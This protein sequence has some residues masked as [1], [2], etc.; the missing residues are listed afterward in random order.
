VRWRAQV[1][2]GYRVSLLLRAYNRREL[3]KDISSTLATSDVSVN[4][5]NSRQDDQTEGV[6]IRLQVTVRD[7]Q[8]LS[9]LLHRLNTVPNVF[10][11]R[12]LTEKA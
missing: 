8:Q 12:R 10:E 11:A 7:Y 3:I 6:N 1:D 5:I 4:Q 9:D 2:A